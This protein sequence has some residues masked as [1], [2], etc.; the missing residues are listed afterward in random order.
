MTG[1]HSDLK[2]FEYYNTQA[3]MD[4]WNSDYN[5]PTTYIAPFDNK[6]KLLKLTSNLIVY[7]TLLP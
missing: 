7:M 3:L 4:L 2:F 5:F 6:Q 1:Y